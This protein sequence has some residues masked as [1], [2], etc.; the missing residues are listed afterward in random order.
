MAP[1][2]TG[3]GHNGV[4]LIGLCG[5]GFPAVRQA[6]RSALP[7]ATLVDVPASEPAGAL[8]TVDVLSPLGSEISAALMDATRPRLIQQFGV[9]LQGVDL[10]AARARGI[11]VANV[12]SAT[13]GNATAVAELVFLHLLA[14]LRRYRQAARSVSERRLGEPIGATLAGKVVTVLGA[15]GIGAALVT[16]LLAF[17]ATPRVVARRDREAYPALGELLPPDGYYRVDDLT[18]A[19]AGAHALVVCCPLTEQ[20]RGLVGAAEL[21]AMPRGGY[22]INVGRGPIVDYGALLD[23]L[24]RGHLAGAGLD[25]TWQEPVDPADE[26]LGYDVTVTPHLGGVTVESYTAMA[27]AFAANVRRLE[28]GRP[29]HDLVVP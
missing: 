22:L 1:R 18:T 29:L 3:S 9:G 17:Q 23:A 26:L 15:G 24:R 5:Q 12:P 16:R 4:M 7:D 27:E 28:A 19:L 10:A 8:P 13:S 20:T 6:L 2:R 14:H 21:A 11:P 25:V